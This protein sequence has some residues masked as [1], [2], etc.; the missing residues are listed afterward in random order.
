MSSVPSPRPHDVPDRF[1]ERLAARRAHLSPS[2]RRVADFV[3]DHPDQ[4]IRMSIAKLAET[5]GVSEPTVLRFVRAL[6]LQRYPELKLLVGQSIVSGTPYVHADV[7]PD[8]DLGTIITK[9]FDSSVYVLNTVQ[10]SL[11]RAAMAA[12]VDRLATARRIDCFGT[13]AASVL[14]IEAQQKLM[15]LGVPTVIYADTH[16]Q[17]M[18]AATLGPGD[19]ALCFSHTGAVLDTVKM[20]RKAAETG[21]TVVAVTR[22][23]TPLA[24]A[25]DI[26]LAVDARENTEVYAPMTSRVAHAVVL[27]VLA[28][29]LALRLGEPGLARLR[30]VKDSLADLRIPPEEADE[31]APRRP[32]RG[33]GTGA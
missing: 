10:A 12:A 28:T 4:V 29:A 2:E 26:L 8:D 17:R 22:P 16:L 33:R 7:E 6:G 31:T 27:D 24:A 5:V 15:R 32:G 18:A 11:D 20:A 30:E 25:A 23:G 13:G 1:L 21:A 9:L 19:V 3:L 14:A